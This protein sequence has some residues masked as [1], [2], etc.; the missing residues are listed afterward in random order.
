MV[1]G[2]A[3]DR[4]G[5]E[6][7][8]LVLGMSGLPARV[9]SVLALRRWRLGRLD[10]VGRGGLGRGRGVLARRGELLAQLG[11]DLLE[12]GE[13]RLQD[14]HSRLEPSAVGATDR[15][16]GSHGG[17]FYMP[18]DKGTTPVNGHGVWPRGDQVRRA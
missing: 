1:D 15:V 3:A 5:R 13:F 8:A 18:G 16:L 17:R 4:L 2:A 7:G 11:D 10:D 9:T 6:G 14:I 12:G